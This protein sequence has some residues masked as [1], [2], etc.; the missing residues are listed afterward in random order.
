MLPKGKVNLFE[1]QAQ[2]LPPSRSTERAKICYYPVSI[3]TRVPW[4]GKVPVEVLDFNVRGC[5]PCLSCCDAVMLNPVQNPVS[6]PF[7]LFNPLSKH[8]LRNQQFNLEVS[9]IWSLK[10]LK[11]IRHVDN[12]Q[13]QSGNKLLVSS[14]VYFLGTT[15]HQHDI[16]I[17]ELFESETGSTTKLL[18]QCASSLLWSASWDH[19]HRTW[20]KSTFKDSN[21]PPLGVDIDG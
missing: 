18:G 2:V 14:A 7:I 19:T 12:S 13:S 1:E 5:L 6:I 9:S 20:K 10:W 8:T 16:A 15:F 11:N 17:Q 4:Q 3:H 21:T